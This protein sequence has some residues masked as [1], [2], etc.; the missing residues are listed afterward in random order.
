MYFNRKNAEQKNWRMIKKG[1]HFL[2]GCSL[3]FAV[4]ATLATPTVHAD[5]AEAKAEV[6]AGTTQ[7]KPS[8]EVPTYASPAVTSPAETAPVEANSVTTAV[9]VDKSQLEAVLVQAKAKSLEGQEASVKAEVV[10]AIKEAEALV[11][12]GSASQE[13]VNQSVERLTQAV[14]SVKEV[15]EATVETT[16]E[17]ASEETTDSSETPKVRNKR[18]TSEG[19]SRSVDETRLDRVTVTKD[20]FDSF[21]KEGGTANYD[22]TSGTIKLTDDVSG[23]VG[24]AYLR[25]KIDPREDFTFTGKV[26]IGDKYEGH[27]VG[28]RPG[29]D[30]VGFVFHTGNVDTIGQSG[31]SIG[32]GTIKNAFGF[33]LDSWHNTSNPNAN[34]NASADP[35]YGNGRKING[36]FEWEQNAFGSFYSSNNAGRV[37]TS[38]SAAKALNPKPNGE[39]VDFKIEYKGQSKEFI[40]TYGSEKWSTNLKTANASIMEPSAKTALN[41][42]NATYALSFLGS[43][44]SGTNLQRVQIEKFEFTAPQIVQVAF[45]D[46]AGH[47]LAASSAIPGDRDQVVNLNSVEAVQKAISKLEAKGYT[48]KEVNSKK[49]ET[50]NAGANTVT[51]RSGGQLLKYVFKE[52]EKQAASIQAPT[53]KVPVKNTTALTDDEKSSVEAAVKAVNPKASKV[54]VATDGAATVTFEDGSTATLTG[55]QTV[56]EADS[57]GVKAPTTKTPVQDTTALTQPEKDAVKAAVEAANPGAQAEVS[58]NGETTVTF[59]DGSTATLTGDK[60]VTQADITAPNAPVVNPVKAGDKAITGTAEAGST[61]E[62]TLPDGTK[63]SAKAD[64]DGKFSI[65]VSGLNAGDTVSVTATDEAG[66]P[67]ATTTVTVSK[68]NVGGKDADNAK[69]PVLTPVVDPSNLTDAEKAKVAE[70]VKKANPTATDVKVNNDGSVVVTFADGSV[71]TIAANKVVKEATKESSAQAPAKKAGAKELPNTGTKQSNASLGLALLAAVTGG[72]LISKKRKEEE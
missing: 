65:P 47:E 18:A 56:K 68:V 45:Y 39:W 29:G 7:A 36:K 31:A 40:V 24:S 50:Y 62:V 10:A 27:T 67:S 71:A 42:S 30:G 57:K 35:K 22:E 38:S 61:V 3:V 14:A 58:A 28:D 8:A 20:N 54:E 52:K 60:T 16:T 19:T 17:A 12:N 21:F 72:L 1:K 64:K 11:A 4:G 37:T 46:E 49:A 13:Q 26:D 23:Q 25:F 9:S 59:P 5:T 63:V 2:F 15:T 69:V 41:N 55:A 66:N 51:L 70:E 48:L 34:Q 33:K 53:N 43:T 44:G 6:T 32:M